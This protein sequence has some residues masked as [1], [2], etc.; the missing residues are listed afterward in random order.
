MKPNETF[1]DRIVKAKEARHAG[2]QMRSICRHRS[3]HEGRP[4]PHLYTSRERKRPPGGEWPEWTVICSWCTR[5][6]PG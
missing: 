5:E 1:F 2:Q 3:A 6:K 4:M